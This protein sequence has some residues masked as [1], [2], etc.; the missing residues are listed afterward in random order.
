MRDGTPYIVRLPE[1]IPICQQRKKEAN[2]IDT[3]PVTEKMLDFYNVRENRL[4][5][6]ERDDYQCNY[7][8]KQLTR[9]SATLDH[10]HPV[11]EGGDNSA[12]NLITACLQCNARKN[13]QELSAFL[14]KQAAQ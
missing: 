8:K 9:F 10:I 3:K 14:A 12:D 4:Q 5:I 11:S 6:F 1:E 2:R 7:C 13:S